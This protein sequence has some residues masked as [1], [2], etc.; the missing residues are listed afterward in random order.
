MLEGVLGVDWLDCVG[1]DLG[2]EWLVVVEWMWWGIWDVMNGWNLGWG[3][4]YN[5]LK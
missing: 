5:W 2:V 3:D 1:E 4:K